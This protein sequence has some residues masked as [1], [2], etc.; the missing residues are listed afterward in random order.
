MGG[1]SVRDSSAAGG[2]SVVRATRRSGACPCA[3]STRRNAMDGSRLRR[4]V[5]APGARWARAPPTSRAVSAVTVKHRRST[6]Q[7]PPDGDRRHDTDENGAKPDTGG[8]SARLAS[9]FLGGLSRLFTLP[10]RG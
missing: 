9:L 5:A 1:T 2:G 8:L 10:E 4:P 7:Q 6:V 3:V